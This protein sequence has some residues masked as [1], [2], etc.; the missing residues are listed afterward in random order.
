V[1]PVAQRQVEEPRSSGGGGPASSA[2]R[3]RRILEQFHIEREPEQAL[4]LGLLA[5]LWPFMRAHQGLLWLALLLIPITST[6]ALLQPY[7]TKRTLDSVLVSHDGS[8][9]ARMVGLYALALGAEFIGRFVQVY[10][11]QLAGQR[12]MLELRQKSFAHAQRLRLGYY[13]RTPVGRVLTRITNDVDSLGELFSSGAV[14]AVADIVTLLGVVGF[15]LALDWRLTLVAFVALPPLALAVELIRRRARQSF[16]DIRAR[17]AQLNAY[18]SEQV[19]GIQVVQAFGREQRSAEEYAV[20]NEAHRDANFRSIR[21]DA[22]LY[23]VVEAISASC[24]ALML[25]YAA[26]RL[27]LIHTPGQATAYIGTVVAF[28]QYLQQFFVPIRDLSMKYTLIQSALASAERVFGFLD[29]DELEPE[30]GRAPV[31][32]HAHEDEDEDAHDAAVPAVAM[33]HVGF[34]YRPGEPVLRDVSFEVKQGEQIAIVGATGAGKSSTIALLLGLYPYQEG[35][36]R[37]FGRDTRELSLLELRRNFALVSQDVFLFTGT[38]AENVALAIDGIDEA[39]VREAL[40]RVGALDLIEARP[41]GILTPV[42]ERGSNFSAGERQLIAFARALY[43]PASILILD[44]ATAHIDSETEARLQTAVGEL[45]QGRTAIV[46][47]HRLSTIRRA[48]RILVFH[49]GQIVE[50]GSHEELLKWGRVYA[51]LHRLQFGD[52]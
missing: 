48:Q 29:T 36:V 35:S 33:E 19:Q 11:L 16:R 52:N 6:A 40:R 18:L 10:A 23:S 46:I 28:Y 51:H 47:A 39:R 43:H 13:D 38:V 15:M 49:R 2:E 32:A 34:A 7:L 26:R 25:Y 9:W 50:Q 24:V 22:I 12:F 1:K 30:A 14:M 41:N 45:L 3:A 42:L 37:V 44:E 17:V 4:D 27:D 31:H 20:I 5:R 8:L 21:Y